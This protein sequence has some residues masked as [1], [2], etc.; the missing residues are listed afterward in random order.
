MGCQQGSYVLAR[1]ALA[2]EGEDEVASDVDEPVVVN[3][4]AGLTDDVGL[5]R[6]PCLVIRAPDLAGRQASG[7][8]W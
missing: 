4:A 1:L 6:Q 8:R 3:L 5:L 2:G 7:V